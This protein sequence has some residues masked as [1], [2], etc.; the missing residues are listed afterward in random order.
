M[1]TISIND[2]QIITGTGAEDYILLSY[3]GGQGGKIAI[4]TFKAQ[5]TPSIKDG[6][7]WI[8]GVDTN[9]T[10]QGTNGKTPI[11]RRGE[12]GIEYSYE[13]ENSWNLLVPYSEL[14][15]NFDDLTDEQKSHLKMTL[16]DLSAEDI[17][18]LQKPAND[19]IDVLESTNSEMQKAKDDAQDTADHPTYV[20]VDYY[21][22]QWNKD[23]KKYDKTDIYVKGE[24]GE[25][26]IQGAQ[27]VQGE[28]GE[29]GIQGKQGEQGLTPVF[30]FGTIE[31]LEP[32]QQA[33][34]SIVRSGNTADG[35]PLYM[36][37]LAIPKGDKGQN[38]T[39]SG[40][41]L[42]AESGLVSG[43]TYLFK[44]NQNN[45]AEGTFVEY[46]IP[47]ID[48]SD[49]VTDAELTEALKGK[50]GIIDDLEEIRTNASNA[51]KS[52]PDEYITERELEQRGFA[53]EKSVDDK[54][55]AIELP[56]IPDDYLGCENVGEE[57]DD[58]VEY[59]TTSSQTLSDAEKERVKSNIGVNV[60]IVEHG[61]SDTTFALT[62]NKYHRWGT[63][64][65]LTLTLASPN[66]SSVV[67]NYAFEFTSGATAT[68]LLVP[69]N[70]QWVNDVTIEANKRYQGIINSSIGVLVSVTNE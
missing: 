67:N 8:G 69:S 34:A 18:L 27:G 2:F 33:A 43:K 26:G 4:G 29:Q 14:K 56:D 60:P 16:D 52:I 10:A 28:Q 53:T 36:V 47:D 13:G 41:V 15:L 12:S 31:T 51:L 1:A 63:M 35:N 7:W 17:A 50:Q 66:D 54:I 32:N 61:T 68:T 44:P 49:L 23:T 11:F 62:P 64:A 24:Q 30:E 6:K 46:E 65:S 20:G 3:N 9:V 38:G 42:V 39:G 48:T 45:S 5:M 22:Y 21:V 57:L 70:I 25:Q 59:L 55:A 37:S 40:N 58:V 19:M